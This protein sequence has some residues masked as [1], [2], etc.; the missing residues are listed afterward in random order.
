ML[1]LRGSTQFAHVAQYQHLTGCFHIR[2]VLEGSHHTRRIGIVG[3][4]HQ[5]VVGCLDKHRAVVGGHVVL[6]SLTNLFAVNI[7]IDA[8]GNGS[9]QVVDIV[10]ANEVGL[11]FVP[12]LRG[13][14]LL[15]VGQRTAP[16]ELQERVATDYLTRNAA[17]LLVGINTIGRTP[18]IVGQHV[19]ELVAVGIEEHQ[20]VLLRTQEVIEF[21]LGLHHP[22]E[23]AEALQMGTT[24]VGDESAGGLGSLGQRLDVARMRGT[25]LDD[26]YLVL[27]TQTEQRLGHA[28]IVV[29]VALGSQHIV[30]L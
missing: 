20:T 2:E 28:Y 15:E 1:F 9:Q 27:R 22:F 11:H 10:G 16:A 19:A 8:Y 14:C 24:H 12:F 3:I 4:D 17:V 7:E 26:G 30:L 25:H 29:E 6:Q 18:H 13:T 5:T 21:A 23:R